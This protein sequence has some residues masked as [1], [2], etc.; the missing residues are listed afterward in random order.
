MVL[1]K[2]SKKKRQIVENTGKHQDSQ[3]IGFQLTDWKTRY[4]MNLL[5]LTKLVKHRNKISAK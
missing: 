3:S 4:F 2:F 5:I 1:Q